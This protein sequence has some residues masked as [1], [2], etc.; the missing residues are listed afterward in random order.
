MYIYGL[1][2]IV[3]TSVHIYIYLILIRVCILLNFLGPRL[4]HV[5]APRLGFKPKL[6]MLAYTTAKALQL[7]AMP[8]P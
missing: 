7:M 8:D 5:E 3:C 6:H 2:H 4:R 1:V